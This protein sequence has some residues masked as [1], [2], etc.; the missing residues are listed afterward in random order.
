MRLF[1]PAFRF[2]Y[3]WS[4]TRCSAQDVGVSVFVIYHSHSRSVF[5]QVDMQ[6]LKWICDFLWCICSFLLVSFFRPLFRGC[7]PPNPWLLPPPW[8]YPLSKN[9]KSAA[10]SGKSTTKNCISTRKTVNLLWKTVC[11]PKKL[12]ICTMPSQR[13]KIKHMANTP[14]SMTNSNAFG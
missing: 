10:K 14:C 1:P 5:F 2:K 4:M 11:L 6:F 8:S 12:Q 9:H 7:Q 3:L 13:L